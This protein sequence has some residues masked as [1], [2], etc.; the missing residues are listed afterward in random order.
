MKKTINC[1]SIKKE[2]TQ[3]LS[4]ADKLGLRMVRITVS[5]DDMKGYSVKIYIPLGGTKGEEGTFKAWSKEL[6]MSI[7]HSYMA[8]EEDSYEQVCNY[9]LSII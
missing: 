6:S 7:D 2:L 9:I 5:E 3:R 1:K 4:T 8:R